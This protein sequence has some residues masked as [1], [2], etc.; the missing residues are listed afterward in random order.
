MEFLS[1]T[2]NDSKKTGI[3]SNQTC[4]LINNNMEVCQVESNTV[5]DLSTPAVS[6]N[7]TNMCNNMPQGAVS[8]QTNW[9]SV[10]SNA[11]KDHEN[12][13]TNLE[14][15]VKNELFHC[16]KFISS[17][18][19]IA[20]SWDAKSLC[21]LFCAEFKVSKFEQ[22]G[23]WSLYH[24]RISQKLNKK[25]S[26]VSNAMQNVFKCMYVQFDSIVITYSCL[27]FYFVR[28]FQQLSREQKKKKLF[29]LFCFLES[30]CRGLKNK[31]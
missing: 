25:R 4:A 31:K 6:H 28:L 21:Q 7:D 30:C 23:W 9:P 5:S 26:E 14:Q 15:Y 12:T 29:L 2:K 16:L 27:F 20:F 24:E 10:K 18:E 13:M 11:H 17:P 22:T 19:M 3:V 1:K 8:L